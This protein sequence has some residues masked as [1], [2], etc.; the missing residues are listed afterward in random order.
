MKSIRLFFLLFTGFLF[1]STISALAQAPVVTIL[2]KKDACRDLVGSDGILDNGSIEITVTSGIPP[3]NLFILGPVNHINIPMTLGVPF[4]PTDLKPGNYVVI[5]QD[6]NPSDFNGAFIINGT[7]DITAVVAPGFPIN[8]NSCS[9]PNGQIGINVSGG[10]GSYSFSWTATNG[11]TSTA[12]DIGGLT[13][14][15]YTVVVSDN[16]T[17]CSQTIGPIT[18]SQPPAPSSGV[19]NLT[20]PATICAGQ[21]STLSV[22]ITG[23]TGPFSLNITGLGAVTN[24]T[25]GT[26]ITVTPAVNTTYTLAS[27]SD[28][29]GCTSPTVSGSQ[30]I[31]VVIP[32]NAGTN[33]TVSACNNN[34]AFN[35][36]TSLGGTPAATGTWTQLSGSARPL[37]G[38][39]VDLNGATAGTYTFRYTVTGTAPCPDATAVVTV[40]VVDGVSAG[41]DNTVA[42]CN[43]ATAFDLF[44]SLGGT[45]DAGGTWLQLSGTTRT[46]TGNNVDLNGAAAGA[47]TFRYTV[48]GTTPCPNASAVVT[49][50]VTLAPN[51]GTNNTVTSCNTTA[52]FNLFTSLGGTPNAGGTWLQLSGT[53]RPITGNNVDLNGATAGTYTFQY[54]VTGAAPCA[55]ATAVVTVN[56]SAASN[57]GTDNTV[58]VCNNNASLN[59]FTSLG[60]TPGAGGTWAQLTGGTRTITGNNVDMNGAPAGTYTFRYT[61]LGTAPC[62]NASA[63]VTVNAVAAPNAG[64]NN[65]V[66]S[67]NNNSALNLFT[68]LGGTP[69]ATGTWLQLTGTSRP[70]TGNNVDLNGATAGTYTFQYTVTGTA[71][72]AN[73]VAVVT[74]NVAASLNAGTNN[75]VAACNNNSVFNL[76]TSLGGTPDAGG[77]W[78]QLTG[79]STITISG[80]DA[81]LNGATAGT[82][83]FRYTLT[84]TPPCAN[85]T[86]VVTVNVV[87]APN[88]GTNNT[89]SA[90]NNN[91]AFN[92]FTSLGGTPDATG[93]WTQLT[94]TTR[95]ITGNNVDLNGA[96]AG[97][98]TFRYTVTGTAPCANATAVV[99]VNVVTAANAGLANTVSACN[100][101]S[102]FNLFTSLNGTPDATGIWSQLTGA[103]LVTITGN[104]GDF[105]GAVAGA[106][107]FQYAV[108]A[109][110]PCANAASILTV[111]VI[112]APQ[113]GGNNT[114]ASCNDNTAFNLFNS[115]SGTPD[116][117]GSW[118]QIAGTARAITGNNV[119]LNGAAA[120]TYTFEYTVTGTAPC[121]NATAQVVVNVDASPTVALPLGSSPN[122][123]CSGGSSDIT[124][125]NSEMGVSYQLRNNADN[126]AVG[127]PVIGNGGIIP[128]PTGGITATTTYNVLAT[129]GSCPPVQLTGT[130][131]ITVLGVINS[132]LATSAQTSPIC[133]GSGTNIQVANSE[134]G[135]NYQLRNDFDNSAIGAPVAGTG[136]TISLPSGNLTTTTTFNIFASNGTCSIELV[137][138]VTVNVDVN[139]DVNL[140]VGV[141][142]S[143]LCVGGST[144]VT[145]TNA[146]VGVQYQLRNNA[147][148]SLIGGPM[149]GTN[150]VLFLPTFA[151][152]TTTTFNVLA[153]GGVCTPVQLVNTVTVTV[154][155]SV[156]F[157][158][159]VTAQSPT[160]CAGG[161]TNIEV[162]N[163]EAGVTYQ[164]RNDAD[165]SNI[166]ASVAGTG[167]NILF[168]T[169][170]LT[171]TITYNV[172]AS[173]GSC[174]IELTS[175]PT[176]TVNPSPNPALIV[177]ALSSTICFNSSTNIQVVGS[178]TG[179]SYQLRDNVTNTPV[180][181]PVLGNGATINLPTGTLTNTVTFNIFAQIG[182]CSTQLNTTVTVTVLASGDPLC[183]PANNCATVIIEPHSTPVTCGVLTPDGTVTFVITPPDPVLNIDGVII[184]INGPKQVT[185]HNSFVFTELPV[186][187]YTYRIVYGDQSTPAC[188]KTGIFDVE[189]SGVAGLVDF[190]IAN[191]AYNCLESGGTITLSNFIGVPNTD[192]AY[193][194]LSDGSTIASGTITADQ[195]AG[196]FTIPNISLGE[197]EV[198]VSQDQSATNSCVGSIFSIF[199]EVTMAEPPRGC[200]LFV[201]NIFTPNGDGANDLLVI[202]NLPVNSELVISNRWGKEVYKSANYQ[203][204]WTGDDVSDG[205][206][207]YRLSVNGEALT[208][209]L[210]IMRG[211]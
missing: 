93:T 21:S 171:S 86:S 30:L 66:T 117:G 68:S 105:T 195:A 197:Y 64:T 34:S 157:N 94:G 37:T 53:S 28:A 51:A 140:A 75:T 78:S 52:A 209:W 128:L 191:M 137:N 198:Q 110:A 177:S 96:T 180:G 48:I 60:G 147:D 109:T 141:V 160:L 92:L 136:G 15:D 127:L 38:N 19:L 199:K 26:D 39:N 178:E 169:G 101:N 210:E 190:E 76:F 17:N 29:S 82:Y 115:L 18:I 133:A 88:A 200:G 172:L 23:G 192:Y 55:N 8:S 121:A 129:N 56:V 89:V 63:V 98:Y 187:D 2:N 46:I 166:G 196:A 208:G 126:S 153:T 4:I 90:C 1:F 168:P 167:G 205:I 111:N 114:V 163:S 158:L 36:F 183:L 45:P 131:T 13:A 67:C 62:P 57:A 71:P 152:S 193:A 20:G 123:V 6:G 116:A 5:V 143:P 142:V 25:S 27:I 97:T 139:P 206:Y 186:G 149:A 179:V 135:V 176:V 164:L 35:L 80:N 7:S 203:N 130:V 70:I 132:S 65:T 77:T 50:N 85:A 91:A 24:Y 100:N 120:G 73:A 41:A 182:P 134:T 69:D 9:T 211:K 154:S 107:T 118:T 159:A 74:V 40:N 145:V 31:T 32:P 59:L 83:T 87:M 202:L 119:N 44:A 42:A 125:T 58:S 148:N 144:E 16:G 72:C 11:F 12:E 49:I 33:N 99:T 173:N 54:T 47:Y 138:L 189:I 188:I 156:A 146:Q 81:N 150:S 165:N 79:T 204:N 175:T 84:G 207:Y 22:T 174:S 102:T 124:V 106:Y 184:E 95:T 14:G 122:P 161:N 112:T 3:I 10:T 61:V 103:S 194:V 108:T 170:N 151:L 201:P 162:A 185:Q 104:T 181:A 155:G 113:A 43:N